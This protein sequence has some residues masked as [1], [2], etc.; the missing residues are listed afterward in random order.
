MGRGGKEAITT[1]IKTNNIIE[2]SPFSVDGYART[3]LLTTYHIRIKIKGV[4]SCCP[5]FYLVILA[6]NRDRFLTLED[7]TPIGTRQ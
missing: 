3:G 2:Q 1:A 6:R 7:K 5:S 4:Y